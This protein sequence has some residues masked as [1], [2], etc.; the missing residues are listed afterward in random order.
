[1]KTCWAP[2]FEKCK[3]KWPR[4]ITSHQGMWPSSKNLQTVNIEHGMEIREHAYTVS[5]NTKQHSQYGEQ[6]GDPENTKKTDQP[7]NSKVPLPGIPLS[8]EIIIP[9]HT[10]TTTSVPLFAAA[11]TQKSAQHPPTGEW[12]NKHG[13]HIDNAIFLR[14]KKEWNNATGN[15]TAGGRDDHTKKCNGDMEQKRPISLIGGH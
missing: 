2:L 15:N 5:G 6:Q 8:S 14:H 1:M 4:C 12:R 13:V 11:R 3:S 9:K 10:C 7:Q